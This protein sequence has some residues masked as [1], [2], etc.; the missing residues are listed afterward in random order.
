MLARPDAR[1]RPFLAV[2]R[3]LVARS[4]SS[5]VPRLLALREPLDRWLFRVGRPDPAPIVLGH[6]RIF[7]LPTP[8]GLAF[9]GAL[10]IML[11]ASI[12]YN[13]SLGYA[14]VFLLGG[15]AVASI[16]HA[17]RNLLH[18]SI[19][20]GRADPVFAGERASFHLV[21]SNQRR[22]RRPSLHL[23]ARG[24]LAPFAIAAE[25]S[26][27][28]LLPLPTTRRGWMPLGRVHIETTYPL[29]LIR[30]W[31]VLA[32]DQRCLV[33]PAP[34]RLPPPLPESGAHSLGQ[35]SGAGGDDDFAGLRPH[36]AADSP[37][38]VAWKILARGGP[39]LTKQFSGLDGGEVHLDWAALPP[40]LGT[41]ARLSRLAAW[42]VIAEQRGLAFSLALPGASVAVGR[43]PGHCANCL[44]RLALFGTGEAA[45]A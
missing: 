28:V 38:H 27:D 33:Y 10:L 4:L 15:V 12:N 18:L 29:G 39:M 24:A 17:F 1:R 36:Q 26:A 7:V 40:P 44:L 16:V 45:D 34:E 20:P 13:L 11:F 9:A 23:K 14:L 41:E 2:R 5:V 6:R 35:R 3:P 32:P 42:V 25:D 19:T 37:R 22:A 21:V 8:A 31:S 43:G 30:A